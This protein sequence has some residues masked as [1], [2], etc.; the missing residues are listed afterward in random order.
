MVQSATQFGSG[1]T[2]LVEEMLSTKVGHIVISLE[3]STG[4]TR[5][6]L[7]QSLVSITSLG[8]EGN[9]LCRLMTQ[10]GAGSL[11]KRRYLSV[12]RATTSSAF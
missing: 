12:L 5:D 7:E 6:S 9:H 10:H 3:P 11:I 2:V 8:L 1:I 4:H